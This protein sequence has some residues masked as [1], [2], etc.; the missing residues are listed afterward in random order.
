MGQVGYTRCAARPSDLDA[1]LLSA[2]SGYPSRLGHSSQLP[3][4][5]EHAL[6]LP[7]LILLSLSLFESAALQS[8]RPDGNDES[9]QSAL[10]HLLSCLALSLFLSL[11]SCL[12]SPSLPVY[13]LASLFSLPSLLFLSPSSR[14]LP[15]CLLLA[16]RL[17]SSLFHTHPFPVLSI[18]LS[19]CRSVPVSLCLSPSLPRSLSPSLLRSSPSLCVPLS[20][21]P[22][23]LSLCLSPWLLAA[24][25]PF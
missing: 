6:Y 21:A 8:V 10:L 18:R 2:V 23:P 16:C 3:D 22:R 7:D 13:G 4:A 24:T 9:G 15:L 17:S 20:F 25:A 12:S 11:C 19:T 1:D 5:S 14:V